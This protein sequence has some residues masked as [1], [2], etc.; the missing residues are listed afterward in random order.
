MEGL[1]IA[2]N[3]LQIQLVIT[4]LSAPSG[5]LTQA[6]AVQDRLT[7]L[8]TSCISIFISYYIHPVTPYSGPTS[9]PPTASQ[10]ISASN[11]LASFRTLQFDFPASAP[12]PK[13]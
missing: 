7:I 12:S 13:F 11:A 2:A 5:K 10:S 3:R 1:G 6:Q 8:S 9:S 4:L